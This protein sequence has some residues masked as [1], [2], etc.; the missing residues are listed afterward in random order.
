MDIS[1]FIE[2]VVDVYTFSQQSGRWLKNSSHTIFEEFIEAN[3]SKIVWDE[4]EYIISTQSGDII[5]YGG[6]W[7]RSTKRL[8]LSIEYDLNRLKRLRDKKF[9]VPL[10]SNI[11]II[12]P[13]SSSFHQPQKEK[14]SG[15]IIT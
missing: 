9:K 13:S 3:S 15:C 6:W 4:D 8:G 2:D 11:R 12:I 1:R 14:K 7:K 5:I 10:S